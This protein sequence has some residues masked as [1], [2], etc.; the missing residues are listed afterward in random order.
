MPMYYPDLKSVRATAEAMTKNK[1][2]KKY[3]GIIP[4]TEEDLPKARKELG[5]YFREVWEDEINAIEIE[6]AATKENYHE[7]ISRGLGF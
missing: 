2:D 3:K 5:R 6:R 4:K 7:A 1:G